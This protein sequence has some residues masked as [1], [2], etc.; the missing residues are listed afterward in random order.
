M[1]LKLMMFIKIFIKTKLDFSDYS[2]DSQFFD[3]I[4]KKVIGKRKDKFQGK[5]ISK[6]VGLKTNIY[7][8]NWCRQWRT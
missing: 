3:P 7:F 4:N 6:L 1:K 5:I 2:Q 8:I